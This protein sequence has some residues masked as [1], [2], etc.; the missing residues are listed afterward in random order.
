M[1]NRNT[2]IIIGILL[3]VFGAISMGNNFGLWSI[4]IFFK[5]WWTLF[6][7]IPCLFDLAQRK[8]QLVNVTGMIVG[9]LLLL[10]ET[11][12]MNLG[13]IRNLILPFG[14]LLLGIVLIVNR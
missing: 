9:G 7:V 3:I 8:A 5:G 2:Q 13:V 12:I 1:V 11:G 10:S 14:F 6:I 4:P